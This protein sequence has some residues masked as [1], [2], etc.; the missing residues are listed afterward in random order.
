MADLL[1][2]V[3]DV[4]DL[5]SLPRPDEVVG[6]TDQTVRLLLALA[7]EEGRELHGCYDWQRLRRQFTF[8]T[9]ASTD[10][11][12]AFAADWGR[13]VSNTFFNRSQRRN[14]LG[15]IT[16]QQWQAIQA[17]PQLNRV[18]LAFIQRDDQF[19]VTPTPG[20]N[21]TIAYEYI[22]RNW[23]ESDAGV[24]QNKF[25]ADTDLPLL[26]ANLFRLGMRWRF[27]KSKG[28]DYAEDFR[29]YQTERNQTMAFDGGNSEM[30]ITGDDSYIL[31]PNLP[32]GSFPGP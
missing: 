3:Q 24:E 5:L 30:S 14:V 23:C 4:T 26:D 6:S 31:S 15:P 29:T 2:I 17:Q 16:P 18:F 12:S 27:L 32:V 19:L 10:Q 1:E 11:A 7:N 22:T 9:I 13:W 28:L 20:A 21:E 8:Q 25:L